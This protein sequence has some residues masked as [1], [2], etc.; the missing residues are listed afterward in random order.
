MEIVNYI[1]SF[2]DFLLRIPNLIHLLD[3]LLGVTIFSSE[4]RLLSTFCSISK[5]TQGRPVPTASARGRDII[6]IGVYFLIS[7]TQRFRLEC[8]ELVEA[9]RNE[10]F[11]F[12][13][14]ISFC[15]VWTRASLARC[16]FM[17]VNFDIIQK[18]CYGWQF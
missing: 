4:A 18:S 14:L 6:F 2:P 5:T 9:M 17:G 11:L 15:F 12:H 7:D 10:A 8:R 16:L 3:F 13:F 1:F